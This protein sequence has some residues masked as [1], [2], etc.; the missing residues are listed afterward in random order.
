MAYAEILSL[1]SLKRRKLRWGDLTAVFRYLNFQLGFFLACGS[2]LEQVPQET[3][4][5][6]LEDF[7]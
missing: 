4:L 6:S 1:F 2:V 7:P 3:V 5:R